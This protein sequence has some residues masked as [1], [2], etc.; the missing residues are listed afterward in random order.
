M[1]LPQRLTA[2]AVGRHQFRTASAD[3]PPHN[4]HLLSP[5]SPESP[6]YGF[7]GPPK[8]CETYA[9]SIVPAVTGD[10]ARGVRTLRER[11]I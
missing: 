2:N 6:V 9:D 1:A 7:L 10:G 3:A 8:H 4:Q 5:L 11:C